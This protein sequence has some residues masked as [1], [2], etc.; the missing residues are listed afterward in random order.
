MKCDLVYNVFNKEEEQEE[1]LNL[2]LQTEWEDDFLS[3][4]F[5]YASELHLKH[6][7]YVRSVAL[8]PFASDLPEPPYV[9]RAN[10]RNYLNC[11][12]RLAMRSSTMSEPEKKEI[13]EVVNVQYHLNWL[14]KDNDVV[15]QIVEQAREE[16]VEE[17]LR[18]AIVYVVKSRFPDWEVFAQTQVQKLHKTEDLEQ[19]MTQL[20]A[21]PD[22]AA[23]QNVLKLT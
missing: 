4:L 13:K 20:L 2:E 3:R 8:L 21:V 1:I 11:F 7:K 9:V 6:R 18:K 12:Y 15:E 10:I 17:G 14:L 16:G 22:E 23:L 5:T 19:L